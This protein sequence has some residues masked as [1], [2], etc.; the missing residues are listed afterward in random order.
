MLDRY[1]YAM[2]QGAAR[3][4]DLSPLGVLARGYSIARTGDGDVVSHI[5]QVRVGEDLHVAVS[6]GVIDCE[7]RAAQSIEPAEVF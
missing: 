7:V 2:R 3:L 5:A 1:R 4:S 6:D